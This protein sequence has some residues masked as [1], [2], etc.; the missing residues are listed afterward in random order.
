MPDSRGPAEHK[1][2]QSILITLCCCMP[3]GIVAIVFSAMA[4]SANKEGDFTKAHEMAEKANK[5][6]WI[7]FW[8]GLV[9]IAINIILNVL[10]AMA[11]NP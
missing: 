10:A 11:Q 4:M 9:A 5:F 3:F 6:G 1:L 2:A 7:G 8:L